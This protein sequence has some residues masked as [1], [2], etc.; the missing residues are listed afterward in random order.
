MVYCLRW[1]SDDA[2]SNVVALQ[3][4]LGLGSSKNVH[5]GAFPLCFSSRILW[6]LARI[7][8]H[9]RVSECFLV[10]PI[11]PTLYKNSSFWFS[12]TKNKWSLWSVDIIHYILCVGPGV[13]SMQGIIK[14]QLCRQAWRD[15]WDICW[16]GG[17]VGVEGGV[18]HNKLKHLI[19][20]WALTGLCGLKVAKTFVRKAAVLLLKWFSHVINVVRDGIWSDKWGQWETRLVIKKTPVVFKTLHSSHSCTKGWVEERKGGWLYEEKEIQSDSHCGVSLSL[21]SFRGEAVKTRE[22]RS[23][24]VL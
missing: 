11:I 13:K 7:S 12:F 22:V 8:K 15:L 6:I 23:V 3:T 1:G 2:W 10:F 16:G 19:K 9:G 14:T 17:G 5:A 18:L 20:M 21:L 24:C 4:T